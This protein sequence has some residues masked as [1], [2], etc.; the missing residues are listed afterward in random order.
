[1]LG[2]LDQ[3]DRQALLAARPVFQWHAR[4]ED[5]YVGQHGAAR[6][7]LLRGK[8]DSYRGFFRLLSEQHIPFAVADD[9]GP[10]DDPSRGFDLVIS[11]SGAPAGLERHVREGGR[12]LVAG[13][14]PPALPVGKVVGARPPTRGSW[15]VHDH[16]L[17]PSLRDTRLI[18]LD[19]EYVELAPLD[20]PLLT[21]VPPAMFGPPEK[22]WVDKVETD[23][24]GLVIADHGRGRMA[25][26]PW[27]VGALYYRH[28]SPGHSGLM[29][30]L[31]DHLLPE[32]RQLKTN[33]HPLVEITVM[34]QPAHGR[35]LVHFV[36]LTGHSDTAYF[37]PVEVRDV[38]VELAGQFRR[39]TAARLARALPVTP[40]GRYRRF[41]L[42][43]LGAYEVVVL[44]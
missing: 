6:V 10:L 9:L 5:L 39:A 36:N 22:V 33:A 15:R 13:A 34:A 43:S 28:S 16:A 19:G 17:L 40:A 1:M 38:A 7:L 23:V 2:T 29:A 4:H 18:F 3:E 11:P 20:K 14:T 26:V 30:D 35:T 24:P 31:V 41:T 25:Y 21:L 37:A 12:L 32:G 42:P 27:D 44:Q 8:Q